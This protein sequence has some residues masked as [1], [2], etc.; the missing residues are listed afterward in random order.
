MNEMIQNLK[1]HLGPA[2]DLY[3][4]PTKAAHLIRWVE[5]CECTLRNYGA[6]IVEL[7]KLLIMSEELKSEIHNK[8]SDL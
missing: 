8:S 5:I 7:K 1:E 3:L 6:A 4:P 2:G